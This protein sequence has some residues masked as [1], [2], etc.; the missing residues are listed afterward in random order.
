MNGHGQTGGK[1]DHG[2]VG[3]SVDSVVGRIT[4][5]NV[6]G[7]EVLYEGR[8]EDRDLV[9]KIRRKL[10]TSSSV[11]LKVNTMFCSIC[12][13]PYGDTSCNHL[14]GREYPNERLTE[15][16]RPYL[17]TPIGAIVGSDIEAREQ[18]I[19]LYP[20]IE[21]ASIGLNFSEETNDVI[22]RIEERKIKTIGYVKASTAPD[23]EDNY[24]V[25]LAI[26][27][28]EN[29]TNSIIVDADEYQSQLSE[30]ETLRNKEIT[31]KKLLWLLSETD[32]EFAN[33]MMGKDLSLYSMDQLIGLY[34]LFQELQSRISSL[35][36]IVADE[37][38]RNTTESRKEDLRELIFGIRR[39]SVLK[40]KI[41][42]IRDIR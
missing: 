31:N 39:D 28:I 21:G 5:S 18:S 35:Q 10:V 30:L 27:L 2:G 17:D 15:L 23:F 24:V 16:A 40:G 32:R 41:R 37:I 9:E 25:E 26:Q 8:I 4:S 14:L 20:A 1:K 7:D 19:V 11:G 34:S 3:K 12:G 6:D 29:R 33:E 42:D 38:S 13:K 22:K 36:G